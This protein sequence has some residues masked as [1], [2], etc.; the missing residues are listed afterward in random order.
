MFIRYLTIN[1]VNLIFAFYL[2]YTCITYFY[3]S[4]GCNFY[5][6]FYCN[7]IVKYN[8]LV[9]NLCIQSKLFY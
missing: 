9:I 4:Y 5:V 2:T 1:Y 3:L 6:D 7:V 8:N